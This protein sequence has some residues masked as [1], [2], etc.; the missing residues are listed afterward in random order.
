[1]ENKSH[2]L[3]AGLFVVFVTALLIA[4]AV[5]LT[6]D[7]RQLR[8]YE[9]SGPV[10]LSGLQPQASVRYQGVPVGKVTSISLDP[11]T[12]GHVLVRIA[13]DD[14]APIS[15][16]T[17]ATLGYQGVTGLAF[18]QLD[19]SEPRNGATTPLAQLSDNSR[20]PLKPGLVSKLTDR[21]ER[22]LGQLDEASLR[23]NQLLSIQNQQT[24]ITTVDNFGK[25][26]LEIQQL[27]AQ[28]RTLLPEAAQGVRNSLASLK[29]TSL[30]LGDSADAARTS[31]RAFQQL[32]ERMAAPGGA[33]D[34]L[35]QGSEVWVATNHILQSVTL[36]RLNL[37]AQDVARSTRQLGE[38]VQI[39][40][41][42][43]QALLLGAP[44]PV[45]GPG[46]PGFSVP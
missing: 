16:S 45:P 5:W 33:L 23:L 4:L 39:L 42:A 43:P 7:T 32:T 24:L 14:L 1:M 21:G 44:A 8:N 30:R 9:L 15:A 46:E 18:I 41:E 29:A 27:A 40:R 35:G 31:A 26:A 12:R 34:Q 3:A 11:Q 13:V 36:P 20:I 17:F 10:N 22:V 2:A 37:V 19:D 6:R 25:A 38:L 28:T